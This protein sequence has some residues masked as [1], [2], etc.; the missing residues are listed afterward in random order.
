MTAGTPV[1]RASRG[2][3]PPGPP[4]LSLPA[5]LRKDRGSDLQQYG[6]GA[7]VDAGHLHVRPEPTGLDVGAPSP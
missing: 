2:P 5:R 4:A 3:C 1:R 7:Y 6:P